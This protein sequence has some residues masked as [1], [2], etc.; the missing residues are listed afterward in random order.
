M[1]SACPQSDDGHHGF[2]CPNAAILGT[3]VC[4]DISQLC[5]GSWDC[6]DLEDE[7]PT[8][9]LFYRAVCIIT[10]II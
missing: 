3:K 5:D 6:P 10:S 9:C 4:I 2:L 1:L 8:M 7:H